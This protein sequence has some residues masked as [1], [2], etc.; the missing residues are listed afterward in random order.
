MICLVEKNHNSKTKK[1]FW[2]KISKF[3]GQNCTFL[4]LAANW[5]RTGQCLKTGAL[6]ILDDLVFHAG[7]KTFDLRHGGEDT[8]AISDVDSVI[9]TGGRNSENYHNY[10]T[11]YG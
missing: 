9:L 4:S 10:V 2:P 8:C 6:I 7:N 11:R 5:S 3:L 1:D